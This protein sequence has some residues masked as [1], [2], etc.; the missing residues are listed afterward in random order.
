MTRHRGRILTLGAALVVLCLTLAAAA[1]AATGDLTA[2]G[3]VE[4]EDS[5]VDDCS[6]FLSP[7]LDG[8]VDVAVSPTGNSVYVVSRFDNA[9]VRFERDPVSGKLTPRGC[10][11]DGDS[12]PD[13]CAGSTDGLEDV[14]S[15]TVSPD[16]RS[17][18][19]VSSLDDA[20]VRFGR[21]PSGRLIP[22]GCIGDN[23][24]SGAT[25]DAYTDA[26]GGAADVAVSPDGASVYVVSYNDDSIVRF[27]R[28]TTNGALTPRDCISDADETGDDCAT[29]VQPLAGPRSV[30]VSP[31]GGTVYI[32]AQ[33]DDVILG[34]KRKASNGRLTRGRCFEDDDVGFPS[35]IGHATPG[36]DGP[37]G[38]AVPDNK[39]VYVTSVGDRAV[40][41][42]GRKIPSGRLV[43]KDCIEDAAIGTGDCTR[44]ADG[45]RFPTAIAISPDGVSAYVSSLIGSDVVTFDRDIDTARLSNPRC[46]RD[47]SSAE[48]CDDAA[49]GLLGPRG[50]AVSSNSLSLY[51]AADDDDDVVA[52]SREGP[53]P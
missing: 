22:R 10:I 4:D 16:G 9:I 3:C 32:T 5:A 51:V 31:D 15:V 19:A 48:A 46:V 47:A 41:P 30:A 44:T 53:G 17:V 35:C 40:V 36:L 18:Y 50:L 1:F 13:T 34:F 37:L 42:F 26:L 52:F 20:I 39:S 29:L 28:R 24:T 8:A 2:I 7:A 25:C 45:L 23:D 38:L 43:P 27:A 14:E 49:A 21:R 33:D 6:G 12:G 11:D